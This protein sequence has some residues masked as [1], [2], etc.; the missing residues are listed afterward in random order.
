M[1]PFRRP[2]RSATILALLAVATA[3]SVLTSCSSSPN[4]TSSATSNKVT[5][6][7]DSAGI[8]HI[9]A[10]NFYALGYGE[11]TAFAQDNLCTLAQDFVT[12]NGDR[13]KYFGTKGLSLNYSA[14]VSTTNL[15]SDL[16]W[17]SVVDSGMLQRE[18]AQKPPLGPLPQTLAVYKG[19][20]AGYN[21]Y[22]ASG[23]LHDPTCAGKPWVRP[24]T[25][26]DMFLRGYQIMTEA[27][28]EQFIS[29]L[30]RA[31][32]PASPQAGAATATTASFHTGGPELAA[33][34]ADFESSGLTTNGSNGIGIGSQD[35]AN[36]DG[37]VLA[38]PHFPWQGTER[39][40]MAQLTVPG[41]Y[42]VEGGTLMGFPLIGI[43]FNKDLAWTHTVSTSFRFTVYQLKLVPGDPTSYLVDGKAVK[44][45]TQTVSVDTGNGVVHHTFYTTRWGTVA[46]SNRA[47]YHWTATTAYAIDD[48]MTND[49]FRAV[50]QYFRMGQATS[51]ANLLQVE[52]TY[53]AIPTFNTIAADNTG[54]AYYGDIGNTPNVPTSLIASCMPQG[55]AQTVF[56]VAG[57]VTLDGSRSACAWRNDPGTPV[58]GIFNAAHEPHTIRTDYVENSNSSYWLANPSAPFPAYSPIIGNI[59]V[60]QGLRTQLGNQM[61]AARVA[62]T[63]GF[64]PPKFTLASLQ[65]MWESDKS[66]LT[67]LVLG[68]LVSLC[69]STPTATAT[70]GTVVQLAP[71]CT[72]LAGY[73]G[74]GNLDASGGWLFS[75]WFA[76]A[77][78]Y[79]SASFWSDAFDPA[80]PLTTPSH[81]NTSNPAMLTALA[82]AIE[83]LAQH[84]VPLDAGYGQVQHVTRNGTT[85]PIPGCDTGCFN[86]IYASDGQG[87]PLADFPYGTVN[88]GSSLVMTTELTKSGPISQGI[89]TYSQAT[90]PTSPWYDNMTKLYSQKQWVTLAYTPAQLAAEH[91]NTTTVVTAH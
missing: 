12:V 71:A 65:K 31:T 75:E 16:Y 64:G 36:G 5:I 26:N 44:M 90:D 27:S 22:L 55:L 73:D 21:A 39:F 47:G 2:R 46:D 50:N 87:G 15:D 40:W 14:G 25:M 86:A 59:D 79:T 10:S 35:T 7:R 29:A 56:K 74:T 62:G 76:Y 33:L 83:N 82:D 19:Y 1:R 54:H 9:T 69:R 61:I 34:A 68:S 51:V 91:G 77:P 20:V 8:P 30:V 84:H 11:A 60:Q 42:D 81:L 43:G 49:A 67:Q 4:S 32:P 45:G 3:G 48:S 17:K 72:A 53:L 70:D 38:N 6:V 58:P 57:V 13:S 88:D 80:H 52:S 66:R 41:Q 37:M 18:I 78:S 89:L 24:I 63:D 28:S 85:I 23:K